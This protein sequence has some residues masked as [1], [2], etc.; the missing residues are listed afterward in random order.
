[1][2]DTYEIDVLAFA[3]IISSAAKFKKTGM[4]ISDIMATIV[5]DSTGQPFE[6]NHSHCASF[7]PY[8]AVMSCKSYVWLTLPS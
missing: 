7:S 3:L 1:M 6:Y 5:K 8:P 2:D 4:K